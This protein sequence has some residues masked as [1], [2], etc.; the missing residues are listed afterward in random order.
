MIKRNEICKHKSKEIIALELVKIQEQERNV[1]GYVWVSKNKTS[2]H[3]SK[4]KLEGLLKEGWV[5][6][7]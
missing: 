7:S 1:K 2:K 4:E 3:V 6:S 5:K